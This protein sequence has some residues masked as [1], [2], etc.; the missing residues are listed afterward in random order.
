[1]L[2]YDKVLSIFADYLIADEEIDVL[3]T[4]YCYIIVY[5]DHIR[6]EWEVGKNCF[7]PDALFDELLSAYEFFRTFTYTRADRELTKEEQADIA[8]G[9]EY[10]IKQRKKL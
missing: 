4:K 8:V 3:S 9:M 2:T 6:R 1:M 5:W 10:Y 7:T